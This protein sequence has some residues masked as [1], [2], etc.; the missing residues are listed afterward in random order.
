MFS[1]LM[2]GMTHPSGTTPLPCVQDSGKSVLASGGSAVPLLSRDLQ[3][4]P[5]R[6]LAMSFGLL[7]CIVGVL[8]VGSPAYYLQAI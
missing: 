5:A 2:S 1:L 7:A 3:Y 4:N 8:H 6:K